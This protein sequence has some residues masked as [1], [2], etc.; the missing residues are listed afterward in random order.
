[1]GSTDQYVTYSRYSGSPEWAARLMPVK[2]A[3][4]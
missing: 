2:G 4:S 1:M 3:L